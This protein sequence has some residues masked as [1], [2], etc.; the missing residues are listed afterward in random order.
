MR[1]A[2]LAPAPGEAE[3]VIRE[4]GTADLALLEELERATF[5]SDRLKR[6]TLSALIRSPSAHVLVAGRGGT[7]IGSAVVL[8]R[9]GSRVARLYSLSV[10][11][12]MSGR[13]IGS[14]LLAA[15]EEAASGAGAER[16]RLEVR[17]DNATAISLYERRGYVRIGRRDDYYE[18]G[19]PALRYEREIPSREPF[20]AAL[21]SDSPGRM[22]LRP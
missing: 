6:R 14:R 20:R 1:Q 9:R 7:I 15:A 4:A 2:S 10:D 18:D 12:R 3:T 22:R 21:P 8:T 16:L 5:A 11:R 17:A 13:G 19:A